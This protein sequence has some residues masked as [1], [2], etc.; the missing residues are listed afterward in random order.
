[1]INSERVP[2]LVSFS[3]ALQNDIKFDGWD[4]TLRY[5]IEEYQFSKS[6]PNISFNYD[7]EKKEYTTGLPVLP[8]FDVRATF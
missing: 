2:D 3:L 6:S 5:G 4:M 8:F 1:M 7:Y